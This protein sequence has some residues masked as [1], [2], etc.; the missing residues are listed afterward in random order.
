MVRFTGATTKMPDSSAVEEI[1][2]IYN[3][4]DLFAT[5]DSEEK[6]ENRGN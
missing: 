2:E 5:L 4:M 6:G 1:M 3:L